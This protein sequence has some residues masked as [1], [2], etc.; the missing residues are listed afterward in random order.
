MQRQ[1]KLKSSNDISDTFL[2]YKLSKTSS[3]ITCKI[4]KK[5]SSYN[6]SFPKNI[7]QVN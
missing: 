3:Q 2:D 7:I 6:I 4:I 1:K 5:N